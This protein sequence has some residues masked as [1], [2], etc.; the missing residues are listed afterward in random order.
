MRSTCSSCDGGRQIDGLVQERRN[1][2][3]NALELRLSCTNPSKR[4]ASSNDLSI[5]FA[6]LV[7][8]SGC[9]KDHH[10]QGGALCIDK[11]CKCPSGYHPVAGNSKC[12]KI[13]GK[14][15]TTCSTR[16]TKIIEFCTKY[17][18]K[19]RWL[20]YKR[21]CVSVIDAHTVKWLL[22]SPPLNY[23]LQFVQAKDNET[24]KTLHCWPF[25]KGIHRW[26]VDPLTPVESPHQGPVNCGDAESFSMSWCAHDVIMMVA[27]KA[28]VN[29]M[30]TRLGCSVTRIIST[31]HIHT[32]TYAIRFYQIESE[33][34]TWR[35]HQ[36]ETFSALLASVWGIHRSLVNSPHKGQWRN[37]DVSFDQR[38]NKRRSKQSWGWWFETLSRPLWRHCNELGIL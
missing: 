14:A 38:L 13:G 20:K 8:E 31:I 7:G 15:F 30:L 11:I 19:Y 29:M 24:T 2:I 33:W 25:V 22:K 23:L 21:S 37:F 12:A 5:L 28:A 16:Q 10:C 1:S 36:M 18:I 6:V 35:R 9:L 26:M 27:K 17:Q 32:H 4:N 3:A 34:R